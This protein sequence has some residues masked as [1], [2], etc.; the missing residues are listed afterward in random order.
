MYTKKNTKKLK[1][2]SLLRGRGGGRGREKPEVSDASSQIVRWLR[3]RRSSP[4]SSVEW[5]VP[6]DQG[7]RC[8]D[9]EPEDGQ[10]EVHA[11]SR[12]H[13]EPGQAAHQVGQQ[14]PSVNWEG[15]NSIIRD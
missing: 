12:V 6:A 8:E 7:A 15:G 14:R 1:E 11:P 4:E 2:L 13:A 10:A 5:P 3:F 9:Q